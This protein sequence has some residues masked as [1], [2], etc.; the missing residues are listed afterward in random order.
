MIRHNPAR[1][2]L[3]RR[4]QIHTIRPIRRLL[5]P[6]SATT[7][8]AAQTAFTAYDTGRVLVR[9]THKTVRVM[10][11]GYQAVKKVQKTHKNAK[12]GASLLRLAWKGMDKKKSVK[13]TVGSAAKQTIQHTGKR[14]QSALYRE[15]IEDSSMSAM[16]TAMETG[17]I[18][19]DS[20]QKGKKVYKTGRKLYL[21]HQIKRERKKEL[22]HTMNPSAR[23]SKQRMAKKMASKQ[24]KKIT[25]R[26][27]PNVR[28]LALNVGKKI[29][30]AILT[31][32]KVLLAILVIVLAFIVLFVLPSIIIGAFAPT[33]IVMADQKTIT[34][35]TGRIQELDADFQKKIDAYQRDNK[36]DDVEV[37]YMGEEGQLET[38]WQDILSL[39]AAKFEQNLTFT[40]EEQTYLNEL[41]NKMRK[42]QTKT[43]TYSC[44]GGDGEKPH[45]CT[46]LI[47]QVYSY[48]MEDIID[49]LDFRQDQKDLAR[50]LATSDWASM[51]PGI[52][53]FAPS[54]NF[55]PDD[56]ISAPNTSATRSNIKQTALSLVGKVPYFWGGKSPAGVNPKWGTS[57]LVTAA[58]SST[59]G[60]YQPYGLDCSGYTDWVYKTA[61]A[62]N[63]FSAGGTAYQWNQSYAIKK[64][65]LKVGDLAFLQPPNQS[66]TNHVG[67]YVGQDQ[68]GHNLYCH[69]TFPHG[70]TVNSFSG[71]KFF[72]RPL[73]KFG[74]EDGG[75]S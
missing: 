52:P 25:R 67:I 49:D 14:F 69:S 65:D 5:R 36:Y 6:K 22:L 75:D 73:I 17:R 11:G 57:A 21:N 23:M 51:F 58:G 12:D 54:E 68:S 8:T 16:Y 2:I 45:R 33:Q 53:G 74:D 35:Y 64:E 62:G 30:K 26:I 31:N 63:I 59:T 40:K 29:I 9:G 15:G 38:S 43:E 41:Y 42:I 3:K 61:G 50:E 46:R 48:S 60:T 18:V 32:P 66:G 44:G 70:V 28:Q 24:R 13:K 4:E 34:Q 19:K 27:L 55:N 7:D 47:V 71:F 37:E 72:R 10:R 39:M 56:I 20:I 1:I